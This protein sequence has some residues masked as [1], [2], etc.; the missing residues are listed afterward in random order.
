MTFY[1]PAGELNPDAPEV[2][3][4]LHFSKPSGLWFIDWYGAHGDIEGATMAKGDAL[5]WCK[6][7]PEAIAT[8]QSELATWLKKS[9]RIM[10]KMYQRR[11]Y[12]I[13][14]Q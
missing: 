14:G 11:T 7:N 2:W 5:E 8:M 3:G 13:H 6:A 12:E 4:F 10:A 9:C 1:M